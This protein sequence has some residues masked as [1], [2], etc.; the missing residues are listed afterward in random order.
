MMH[1]LQLM[2]QMLLMKMQPVTQ[3][4]GNSLLMADDSDADDHDSFTVT[5]IAVTGESN[6]SVTG[7]SSYN[8]SGTSITGTY[9]T[10]NC[11][12]QMERILTLQTK[13]LQMHSML[14][15]LRQIVSHI[16]Y[17][18]EQLQLLQH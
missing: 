11:R 4:S 14:E 8:S 18:M 16:Q 6:S 5:Q 2:T 1:Q 10:L 15:I 12:V 7:G 13:M 17:L 3:T 9:G